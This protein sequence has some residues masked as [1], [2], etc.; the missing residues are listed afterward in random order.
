MALGTSTPDGIIV[1][2]DLRDDFYGGDTNSDSTDSTPWDNPR[3]WGGIVFEDEALDR[4]CKLDYATIQYA[5][6]YY[7][8]N[9]AAIY[10]N[11]ASPQITN[12]VFKNNYT[13]VAL[14]GA[15]NPTINYCDIYNNSGIGINNI[16]KSFIINAENNWWGSDSGPTHSG[17]PGGTGVMVSDAVD[18]DP[19]LGSGA[20]NPIIGDVSLNGI[21]QAFDAS[22]ILK[23]VV[24]SEPLAALPLSVADVS[25]DGSVLAYDASL[26]LQYSVGLISS[27]PAEVGSAPAPQLPKMD[28][29]TKKY[30]ALQKAENVSLF[31]EGAIVNRGEEFL[32]PISISNTSGVTAVQLEININKELYKLSGVTLSKEYSQYNMSYWFNDDTQK[33]I[34]AVAG[35]K[36]METEGEFL[37]LSFAANE[38]IRGKVSE[39]IDVVKFYANENDLTK[40]VTA[41]TIEFIGKPTK[42]SLEQ[43]YPNPFNPSTIISYQIPDDNVNVKLIIYNIKGEVVNTLVNTTQNAGRYKVTWNASNKYG[44]KV[45]SGIYIYRISA[46]SYSATKKLMVLK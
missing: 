31:M 6:H 18:Y 10:T 7:Y 46:G 25:G 45:S 28:S 17:N 22:K 43:N 3:G 8:N 21:V 39:K 15:S 37:T 20:S 1:F 5:G 33:L 40:S 9:H 2:T 34:I 11:S 29:K 41:E 12:S 35:T 44:G 24:G 19:W 27:F 23:H 42:Y 14:K 36:P 32:I 16:D 4:S 26:V 38:E 13:S 30:L